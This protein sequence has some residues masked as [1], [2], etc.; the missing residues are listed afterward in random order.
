MNLT[1]D[2][3]QAVLNMIN[4]SN[5]KLT[6]KVQCLLGLRIGDVLKELPKYKILEFDNQNDKVA[7]YYIKSFLTLKE[8]LRIKYLFFPKELTKLIQS[9]YNVK[10]LTQLDLSEKFL[11]TRKSEKKGGKVILSSEYLRKLKIVAKKLYPNEVM[12][13]HSFRKY[14][15][16]QISRVNLTK[17]RNDIGSDVES[18]FKEHLLGHK[19]HYS[20][21]VYNQI[22]NDIN[23]LELINIHRTRMLPTLIELILF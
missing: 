12:R 15:A 10:D 1:R 14:F 11:K 2:I 3:I 20:S 21:K 6:S 19:V 4:N 8:N 7:Q 17:I 13:S 9:I 23:Q 16:T 5:Y 18:N 22:I